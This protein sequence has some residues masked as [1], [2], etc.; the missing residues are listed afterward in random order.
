MGPV[1]EKDKAALSYIIQNQ[2]AMTRGVLVHKGQHC[3]TSS[4]L[5]FVAI[6]KS[7]HS[8]NWGHGV[9]WQHKQAIR[10]SFL[11]KNHI[12]LQFVGSILLKSFPL[13]DMHNSLADMV[14]AI[15]ERVRGRERREEEKK[16]ED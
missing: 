16:R 4:R 1:V 11:C 2:L 3:P 9:H 15:E 12:F 6:C 10:E 7:F 13:Y 5:W 8:E 14:L